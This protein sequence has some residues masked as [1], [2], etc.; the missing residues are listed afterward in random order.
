MCGII[1]FNWFDASL[2]KNMMESLKYRGPDDEGYYL[3]RNVSLSHRRLSIIDLSKKGKQ[4]M[5]YKDLIITYNGEIYNFKEI[6]KQLL[7]KGHIFKSKSDTEVI[8]HAYDE[9]GE[10]CVNKFNGMWAFCIYDKKK[11]ILFLSRDRFGIKPLYYYFNKNKFIFASE[12]KAIRK[13][14]LNFK[15]N[16]RALNFYFYQKYIGKDLTIFENCYKLRPSENLVFDL[17]KHTI[18]KNKYYNLK[19]EIDKCKN[20]NIKKRLKLIQQLISDSVKKRLIADVPVGSFLSGGIDS[21]LISAIIA[22]ENKNFN[23]FSIGFKDKSYNELKYSKIV[24]RYIKTDHYY[25]YLNTNE[26]LIKYI[27]KNMDEP[28][29]DPSILPTYLLSK[30]TREKVTVSLSGDGGDE[31]FGGYDT[32]KGYKI[33]KFFPKFLFKISKCFINLLPP[34]DKKLSLTFKMKKFASDLNLNIIKRHLNWLATFPDKSRCK[35]LKDN[36]IQSNEFLSCN[37]KNNLLSIQINDINNYLSE[38]ILKKVDVASMLNSL[39]VRVPFLDHRLVPLVLS[40]PEKYKIR[41]L[42]TKWLLKKIAVPFLPKKIIYRQ[43]RGF[44]VPISKW[45][46]QNFLIREFLSNQKYY[47]HNFLNYN[48]VSHLFNEH[49]NNKADNS[50]QLWLVFVFNYWLNKNLKRVE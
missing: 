19:K 9:W 4:P 32:Y 7:K 24:S 18:K 12:L 42:E 47:K 2:I 46:K 22:K 41:N 3:D 34:S 28:F 20:I 30:L 33:A 27:I 17:N 48:Y 25:K 50:R 43:K 49:I 5:K 40:L 23:T 16:I 44:T 21:S 8:L 26:G 35:L 36:F 13:H 1:G 10:N 39:E 6:K 45:I 37:N 38:D 31:V 14:K 11:K 29:G 15:I